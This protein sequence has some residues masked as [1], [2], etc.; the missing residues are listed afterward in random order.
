M[1]K[2][3]TI[4]H[5]SQG[6]E[7]R[8]DIHILNCGANPLCP[9]GAVGTSVMYADRD[10]ARCQIASICHAVQLSFLV[11]RG[12]GNICLNTNMNVFS[13]CEFRVRAPIFNEFHLSSWVVFS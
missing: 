1:E 13:S 7:A 12:R 2:S 9:P 8:R 10:N 3:Y 4:F 6:G 11:V 5:L